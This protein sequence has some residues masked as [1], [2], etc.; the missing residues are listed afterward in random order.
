[1]AKTR[2]SIFTAIKTPEGALVREVESGVRTL[3]DAITDPSNW[4]A[5]VKRK[6]GVTQVEIEKGIRD[7]VDDYLSGRK[8][9]EEIASGLLDKARDGVMAELEIAFVRTGMEQKNKELLDSEPVLSEADQD[10][11]RHARLDKIAEQHFQEQR[12]AEEIT[13][14]I[15]GED[16]VTESTAKTEIENEPKCDFEYRDKLRFLESKMRFISWLFDEKKPDT[17]RIKKMLN[18]V[19]MALGAAQMTYEANARQTQSSEL[20]ARNKAIGRMIELYEHRVHGVSVKDTFAIKGKLAKSKKV[21]VRGVAAA[22][23]KP[24]MLS[25]EQ[26]NRPVPDADQGINREPTTPEIAPV[27]EEPKLKAKRRKPAEVFDIEKAMA[28]RDADRAREANFVPKH[29]LETSELALQETPNLSEIVRPPAERLEKKEAGYG[30]HLR[31]GLSYLWNRG[32]QQL[33]ESIAYHIRGEKTKEELGEREREVYGTGIGVASSLCRTGMSYGGVAIT[34]DL[35]RFLTQSYYTSA[36]RDDLRK[37]ITEYIR[38]RWEVDQTN[39]GYD[40]LREKNKR[41]AER[42]EASRYLSPEDKKRLLGQVREI[43]G[44][45]ETRREKTETDFNVA[46]AKIVDQSVVERVTGTQVI[47]EAT[48]T[49]MAVTGMHLLRAPAYAGFALVERYQKISL[50][51]ADDVTAS[52]KMRK[53][54]VDG[55]TNFSKDLTFQTGKTKNERAYNGLMAIGKVVRAGAMAYA[56]MNGLWETMPTMDTMTA[57]DLHE[58]IDDALRVYTAHDDVHVMHELASHGAIGDGVQ[59]LGEQGMHETLEPALSE[60]HVEIP[61]SEVPMFELT[62]DDLAAGIIKSGDGITQAL[63]RVI[64]YNPKQYGYDGSGDELSIDLFARTLS[65]TMAKN[66]GL[67]KT[68]LTDEAKGNLTIVPLQGADGWHVGFLDAKTHQEI[69]DSALKAFTK[70]QPRH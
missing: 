20:I 29:L 62:S 52:E 46:I 42:I 12:F 66:D 16:E 59:T 8:T 1:M 69:T 34:A 58:R 32:N 56:S 6:L 70:A 39:F 28:K 14:K 65:K 7:I 24:T 26:L 48:N 49:A 68:W 21:S 2:R 61:M 43:V 19:L 15:V 35:P 31:R 55:F 63:V 33:E 51:S 44:T 57:G 17:E 41:M 30:E 11:L 53:L 47:R 9:K 3:Y 67:L 22:G 50:E 36:E 18:A 38:E 25:D 37:V 23:R 45:Q 64:E 13:E 10:A 4:R 40:V 54:M 60:V 5:A 27:R